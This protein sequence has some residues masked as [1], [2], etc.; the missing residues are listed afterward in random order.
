[1]MK[2]T[3]EHFFE[4]NHEAIFQTLGVLGQ[5]WVD[6]DQ[7][8]SVSGGLI[9]HLAAVG[10][11][12]SYSFRWGWSW[13]K[14]KP[15][16]VT[17]LGGKTSKT[18]QVVRLSQPMNANNKVKWT[19]LQRA[20]IWVGNSDFGFQALTNALQKKSSIKKLSWEAVENRKINL[21]TELEWFISTD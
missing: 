17:S 21:G 12:L 1:M 20:I 11:Q 16:G 10:S 14:I 19:G 5:R 7:L 6:P 4:M 13:K 18:N 3:S 15:R 2:L 9:W 8:C